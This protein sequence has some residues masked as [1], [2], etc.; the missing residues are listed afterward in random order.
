MQYG[1]VRH[2]A[3]VAPKVDFDSAIPWFESRRPSQQVFV[4][5][6]FSLED[7][8]SP[9]VGPIPGLRGGLSVADLETDAS[10]ARLSPLANFR[11][12]FSEMHLSRLGINCANR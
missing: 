10:M 4:L 12:S 3:G 5:R 2:Q 8:K 1:T 9:R 6:D 7:S 11:V